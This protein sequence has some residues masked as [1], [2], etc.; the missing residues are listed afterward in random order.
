V[1]QFTTTDDGDI[2]ITSNNFTVEEN[3]KVLTRQRLLQSLRTFLG[4]WF[5]DNSI[6]VGYFQFIFQKGTPP[7]LIND[8]FKNEIINT[9]GVVELSTFQPLDLNSGTRVLSLDFDVLTLD[10]VLNIAESVP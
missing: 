9:Q 3:E 7:T 6:G 5:L 10:G 1:S 2:A 4:E 8:L